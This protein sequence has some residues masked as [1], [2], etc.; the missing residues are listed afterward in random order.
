MCNTCVYQ[1]VLA[2]VASRK[3]MKMQN[4]MFWKLSWKGLLTLHTLAPVPAR[5]MVPASCLHFLAGSMWQLRHL[6]TPPHLEDPE[7][8]SRSLARG[9]TTRCCRRLGS[10]LEDG[11]A[12]SFSLILSSSPIETKMKIPNLITVALQA[13]GES[14]NQPEAHPVSRDIYVYIKNIYT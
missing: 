1:V 14:K 12:L 2:C 6:P 13:V 9:R 8:G 10:E 11:R 7:W 4:C 5:P 3:V